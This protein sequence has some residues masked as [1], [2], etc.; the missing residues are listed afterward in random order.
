VD[1]LRRIVGTRRVGHAGTLD[2]FATGLLLLAWGRATRLLPFLS[3]ATK[4][5]AATLRLGIVT[6]SDD[7]TGA[8]LAT[9][10]APLDEAAIRAA[11]ARFTGTIEQRAPALSAIKQGGEP[12]YRKARRGDVVTPPLRRVH[13]QALDIARID[14]VARTVDFTLT[15]SSGTYVR[16]LARDWGEALGVGGALSALRRLAIGPHRVEGAVPTAEL[17]ERP[18]GSIPAWNARLAAAGLTPEQALA[19]LPA[20]TLDP[21]EARAVVTGRAPARQRALEAGIAPVCPAFRLLDGEGSLLGVGALAAPAAAGGS[22]AAAAGDETREGG[23]PARAHA[24]SADEPFD[25]RLVWA[26]RESAAP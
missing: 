18:E 1:R 9:S 26:V 20:L 2:P 16:S 13:I 19:E 14:P 8:T 12:L 7:T 6:D 17:V 11:G 10:D 4:T 24:P 22:A 15:C 3:A 23:P 21:A 5:Y 25:L